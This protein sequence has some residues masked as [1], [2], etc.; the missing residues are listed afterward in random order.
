MRNKLHRE[1]NNYQIRGYPAYKGDTPDDIV[2]SPFT[3]MAVNASGTGAV[4]GAAFGVEGVEFN[5]LLTA[6]SFLSNP[7]ALDNIRQA[8]PC[9]VVIVR[10]LHPQRWSASY[11][12]EVYLKSVLFHYQYDS[13]RSSTDWL[14]HCVYNNNIRDEFDIMVDQLVEIPADTT[15]AFTTNPEVGFETERAWTPLVLRYQL[16]CDFVAKAVNSA[17]YAA[18]T[19]TPL[20]RTVNYMQ[21]NQLWCLVMHNGY[22]GLAADGLG[23]DNQQVRVSCSSKVMYHSF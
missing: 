6:S 11:T 1:Y 2:F 18:T 12:P 20:P 21:A 3:E 5:L 17:S 9:R 19:A 8:L 4:I 10:D 23:R 14:T 13:V 7:I 22:Q 16:P 15:G